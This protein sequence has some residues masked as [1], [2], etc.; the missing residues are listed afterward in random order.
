MNKYTYTFCLLICLVGLL[1]CISQPLTGNYVEAYNLH[2]SMERDTF[3]EHPWMENAA[4]I[5]CAINSEI[6]ETD[7]TLFAKKYLKGFPSSCLRTEL[8]QRVLLPLHK[9]K[10]GLVT[11]EGKGENIKIVSIIVDG[12]N[13]KEQCVFSDTA[14]FVPGSILSSISKEI[15]LEGVDMLDIRIRA[16]GIADAEAYIAFSRLDIMIGNKNISEYPVRKLPK[17]SLPKDFNYIPF[18]SCAQ[19]LCDKISVMKVRKVIALGESIHGNN[20]IRRL[21]CQLM[22]ESVENQNCKLI[23]W[24]MPMEKSFVYNRYVLDDEFTLDSIELSFLDDQR[25]KFV[26]ELKRYNSGKKGEGK[27]RLLGMDYNS[28]CNSAQNSAIDIFDFVTYLNREWKIPEVDQLS[29]LL[30]EKD[31]RDAIEY[32]QAHKSNLQKLLTTDEIECI[33]HILSL[34]KNIGNDRVKR[35]I[36]RD[37]VMFVNTNFLLEQFSSFSENQAIIYAHSVHVNPISTYP[38][39]H[40]EPFGKYMKNKYGDDYL[41]LLLLTGNGSM[42]IYDQEFNRGKQVLQRPP[43]ES[44][45]S[46]LNQIENDVFYFPMTPFFD[47]IVLSRFQGD[48]KCLQEFFPYNLYQRYRGVFFIKNSY[49]FD[50]NKEGIGAFDKAKS[51][52][53]RNKLRLRILED[54]KKRIKGR[55][56]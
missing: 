10:V 15:L 5:G 51:F 55:R 23:I 36:N 6:N 31:W 37:S 40:C 52:L 43:V 54:I 46:A 38:V 24:E 19:N 30:M 26:N 3:I 4:Y 14:T 7:R 18:Q 32:L 1:P 34:S 35:F 12:I 41:P 50:D 28:V 33:T 49:E 56:L 21:A 44:I 45:E 11:F 22:L 20:S 16:D 17:A 42:T 48:R 27:V 53:V 13:D 9:E 47:T 39:V 2:F 29:V 8:E 25:M